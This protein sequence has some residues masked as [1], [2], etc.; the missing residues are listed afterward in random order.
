M[1]KTHYKVTFAEQV[2]L[3]TDAGKFQFRIGQAAARRLYNQG[4]AKNMHGCSKIRALQMKTFVVSAE[5]AKKRVPSADRLSRVGHTYRE[6]IGGQ[7]QK[8]SVSWQ[9]G[10]A[11]GQYAPPDAIGP[12][13]DVI[14]E[15]MG[16]GDAG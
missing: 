8:P 16:L 13:L 10:M 5:D 6:H 14:H 12:Y 4:L 11:G 9:M 7:S 3:Y 15:R 1:S 2:S